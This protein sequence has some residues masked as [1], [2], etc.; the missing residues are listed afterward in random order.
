MSSASRYIFRQVAIVMVFVTIGLTLAIWLSQSLRFVDMIVN[1]GLPLSTFTYLAVLLMPRF[2]TIVLPVALFAAVL[3]T[4][5]RLITE[6]ELVVLRAAG[7]SHA[8]LVRPALALALV[9]LAIGYGLSLYLL[10]VS[11]QAFKNLQ[12]EIRNAFSHILLQEGVFR[13]V[14]NGVTV[15]VRERDADGQLLGI[16]VHDSRDPKHLRTYM[17][18]SGMIV[19]T[20]RGPRAVLVNGA[21]QTVDEDPEGDRP[22]DLSM[23]YFDR[24]T[25]EI[26]PEQRSPESRWREPRERFLHELFNPGDDSQD[27]A[28]AQQLIAEGH[29]RLVYPW[30][31]VTFTLIALGALLFGDMNRR[32]QV[33]RIVGAILAV[34]LLQGVALA[35]QNM[36]AKSPAAVPLVYLAAILPALASLLLLRWRPR[37]AGRV[38]TAPPDGPEAPGVAPA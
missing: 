20:A 22:F 21:Q 6:S 23:L 28:Y 24:Y 31:A 32:G 14:V 9:V 2:L 18:E 12:F 35:L 7:F 25:V 19:R 1:R 33:P 11:Y 3:F 30:Y 16:L 34:A 17:A 38:E 13:E 29:Q 26:D 37:R 10:P 5:N 4:Y 36:A 15:Y 27:Q 8:A